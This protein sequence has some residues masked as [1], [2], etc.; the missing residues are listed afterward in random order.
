MEYF[1]FSSFRRGSPESAN[2][3]FSA[4]SFENSKRYYTGEGTLLDDSPSPHF[5]LTMVLGAPYAMGMISARSRY[6]YRRGWDHIRDNK[7][8]LVTLKYVKRGRMTLT[9]MGNTCELKAGDFA[10]TRSNSPMRYESAPCNAESTDWMF[11]VF[12]LEVIHRYFPHGVPVGTRISLSDERQAAMPL[13]MS[14]LCEVAESINRQVTE[15]LVDALLK[16]AALSAEQ[17][18]M[19]VAPRQSISEKRIEDLVSYISLHMANPELSLAMVA[20]G[21]KISPRYL[22]HLLKEHNTTFSQLLWTNRLN[23]AKKWLLKLDKRHYG[24]S[25]IAYMTGFKSVAHFSRMFREKFG[26]S[27]REFRRQETQVE[28]LPEDGTEEE[29]KRILAA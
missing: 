13:I 6:E 20:E 8:N 11:I 5:D 22:C 25:E 28:V 2:A 21:C 18:G 14:M 15:S 29:G 7:E 9:Q 23:D 1:S 24:I 4:S 12:P 10:F 17:M 16:E 26:C 27:P 19:Q 3:I